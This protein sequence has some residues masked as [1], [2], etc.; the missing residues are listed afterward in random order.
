[1]VGPPHPEERAAP[2]L[3]ER[4]GRTCPFLTNPAASEALMRIGIYVDGARGAKPTGIGL[5]IRNLVNALAALDR[6][7]EYLLY[8]PAGL[9]AR[10]ESFEFGPLP[11]NFRLRPVRFPRSWPTE[12]PRLWWQWWLPGVLR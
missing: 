11:A 8:Y 3:A 9:W 5:H 1:M 10:P 12:H 4:D 7:N 2:P 6:D